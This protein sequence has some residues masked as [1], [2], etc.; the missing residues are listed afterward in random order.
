LRVGIITVQLVITKLSGE[1][2][3]QIGLQITVVPTSIHQV[4]RHDVDRLFESTFSQQSALVSDVAK[5]PPIARAWNMGETS[6]ET[7]RVLM[8][9]QPLDPCQIL[10][11]PLKIL[12]AA[13]VGIAFA[14][15][16]FFSVTFGS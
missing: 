14:F 4:G 15:W 12:E 1:V 9:N 7:V 8:L 11:L 16:C 2:I 5:L 6:E 3:G 10:A 13:E